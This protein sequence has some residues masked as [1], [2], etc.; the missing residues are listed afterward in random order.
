MDA[1]YARLS[2]LNTASSHSK[3]SPP[4]QLRVE[5]EFDGADDNFYDAFKAIISGEPV[6]KAE[7]SPWTRGISYI[8]ALM[9]VLN[10]GILVSVL[11]SR[12]N[13]R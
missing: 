1:Q 10:L 5:T 3:L 6:D 7:E 8:A 2:K 12:M 4:A 13:R 9:G 11:H